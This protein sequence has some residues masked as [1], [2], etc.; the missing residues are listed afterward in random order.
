MPPTRAPASISPGWTAAGCGSEPIR[1]ETLDRFAEAFAPWGFHADAFSAGYGLSECTMAATVGMPS[2]P[3][4]RV[5]LDPDALA[6]NRVVPMEGGRLL[7]SCGAPLPGMSVAIVRPGGSELCDPGAIGEIWLSGPNVA[8]GYWGRPDETEAAFAGRV[9]GQDAPHLRTGD[10]GFLHEGELFVTGRLKELIIVRGK[11]HYPLDIE[12]TVEQALGTAAP[13]SA[14]FSTEARDGDGERLAVVVELADG[15][16]TTEDADGLLDTVAAAVSAHH[17]LAIQD[18]VLVKPATLPRTGSNKV[19]R[20]LCR[21]QLEAGALAVVAERRRLGASPPGAPARRTP[22]LASDDPGDR[23]AG[24]EEILLRE[25][26]RV[27]GLAALEVT[28]PL[29]ELGVD[30]LGVVELL[31]AFEAALE[32]EVPAATVIEGLPIRSIARAIADSPP[33]RA[34][35]RSTRFDVASLAARVTLD[36]AIEARSAAPASPRLDRVFLTGATGYLGAHIASELAARTHAT[37]HCL[38]RAGT[39]AEGRAR[40]ADNVASYD[41]A[42]IP[43][44]RLVIH[45]GDLARP[46]LGLSSREFE[47]LGGTMDAVLHNG[48]AV[49]FLHPYEVLE[50]TNVSGTIEA[51]RLAS[52]G[53]PKPFHLVSSLGI[54]MSGGFGPES[55][56]ED[57]VLPT[58]GR[59][60]SGYQQSKWVADR[61]AALARTRGLRVAIH[62]VGL[63]TGH[64]ESGRH[65][66]LDEFF[67]HFFKGCIELGAMPD[68]ATKTA[69][70]PV[71]HAGRAIA[72]LVASGRHDGTFHLNHPA[73]MTTRELG[74]A[75]ARLGYPLRLVSWSEWRKELFGRGGISLG[76][77]A[78]APFYPFLLALGEE[79]CCL[80]AIDDRITREALGALPIPPLSHILERCLR[81]LSRSGFLPSPSAR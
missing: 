9:A 34:G 69:L 29:A 21:S 60:P 74:E 6:S 63:L 59:L 52:T 42:P 7:L 30:S 55:F 24:V 44:G 1:A 37:I 19:A 47:E 36:P 23:R 79:Q 81:E 65:G 67:P 15:S 14:A 38:V 33:P 41:L 49:N 66:R 61:T 51:L 13:A 28:Q 25:A 46:R 57:G 11:N 45:R 80:P 20:H 70:V 27:L 3:P 77:S 62:R 17:Q 43:E 64:A 58:S 18:L 68:L 31:A 4:A 32:I 22:A 71:D 26:M 12:R 10:L 72:H 78:L 75:I 73:P 53:R 5:A 2:T 39:D 40:V 54:L 48:A 16:A 35:A 56:A 76:G 8:R 50:A